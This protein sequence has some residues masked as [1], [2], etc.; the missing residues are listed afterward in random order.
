[1]DLPSDQ[2]FTSTEQQRCDR[3]GSSTASDGYA[4]AKCELAIFKPEG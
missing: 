3:F 1:M 4:H 2:I